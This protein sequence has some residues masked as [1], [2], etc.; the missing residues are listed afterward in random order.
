MSLDKGVADAILFECESCRTE[1]TPRALRKRNGVCKKCSHDTWQMTTEY[2]EVE[3]N[4]GLAPLALSLVTGLV[5]L[6]SVILGGRALSRT[7]ETIRIITASLPADEA[8]TIANAGFGLRGRMAFQYMELRRD[9][10]GDRDRQI[11]RKHGGQNCTI[12]GAFFM[13]NPDKPWTASACCSKACF[14]AASPVAKPPSGAL[15][16][17]PTPKDNSTLTMKSAGMVPV[18]CPCDHEFQ[19]RKMYV[20][21]LRACPKC[22]QKTMVSR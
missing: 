10:D 7:V 20:G 11:M 2:Q 12:C 8:F 21:T 15:Q 16:A 19:V 6:I 17:A 13:P 4:V 1:H 22:N 14:A 3:H 9:L 5:P 18:T